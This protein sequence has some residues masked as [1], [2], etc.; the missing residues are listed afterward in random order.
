M[1]V[2]FDFVHNQF[3]HICLFVHFP[4][5]KYSYKHVNFVLSLLIYVAQTL[6]VIKI[7]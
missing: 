6:K 1:L 3:V 7:T 4:Q 2:Q 5:C